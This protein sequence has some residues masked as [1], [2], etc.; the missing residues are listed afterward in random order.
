MRN[1]GRTIPKELKSFFLATLVVLAPSCV[2]GIVLSA[3]LAPSQAAATQLA[4]PAPADRPSFE[5]ASIKANKTTGPAQ[6]NFPIGPGD[7]M[8]QVGGL[9]S[10]KN[11][12]LIN[13][14]NFAYKLTGNVEYLMPGLPDWVRSERFD[15]EARAEG[16]PTKDQFRLMVQSLLADRFK[17]A[18]HREQRNVPVFA[19][20]VAKA[21]KM[22]P[23]LARHTD[24]ST[25]STPAG[26]PY[27]STPA[28]PLPKMPCNAVLFLQQSGPG[29]VRLGGRKVNLQLLASIFSGYD[30][31]D[32]PI[33]DRT[34]F[35]GTF[36]LWFEFMPALNGPPPPGYPTDATGPTLQQ[37]LQE[38]LGLKLESQK[39]PIEVMVVDH[40]ERP[41]EN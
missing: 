27:P 35:D 4:L 5:V 28:V 3:P 19:L 14:V 24:D 2:G 10:V 9:F 17:L 30:T 1:L 12:P 21:E 33:V 20:V 11:M 26:Q 7:A 39:A 34:G 38:Q 13:I 22:G 23:Q 8:R 36:D 29:Q 37:A 32:R 41:S 6:F 18:W 31:F 15:I 25:C 16:A 40:M